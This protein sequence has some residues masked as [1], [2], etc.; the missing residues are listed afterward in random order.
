MDAPAV[1]QPGRR[2]H[3]AA[4][5]VASK[6]ARSA[7][8]SARSCAEV[9]HTKERR[10][11]RRSATAVVDTSQP[12]VASPSS[13]KPAVVAADTLDKDFSSSLLQHLPGYGNGDNNLINARK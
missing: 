2:L 6:K 1:V 8:S 12:R 3:A 10:R 9:E 7:G 5:P 13:T 4:P 11:R